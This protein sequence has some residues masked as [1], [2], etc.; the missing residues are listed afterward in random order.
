MLFSC[1]LSI[2]SPLQPEQR[3]PVFDDLPVFHADLLHDPFLF[4]RDLIH[5]FHG[6]YD[7][8]RVARVDAVA[9]IYEGIGVLSGS[10]IEYADPNLTIL[11]DWGKLP[12]LMRRGAAHIELSLAKTE[13][14][15]PNPSLVTRHSSLGGGNV[16]AA[17]VYR[18]SPGGRRLGEVPAEIAGSDGPASQECRLRFTART[19]LDPTTATYLYEI[20]RE[21]SAP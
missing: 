18:L 14:P 19:D 1:S 16:V 3:G 4:R 21:R 6:L 17:T 15:A 5:Q 8:Q 13:T 10:G 11:L 20:V 7:P 2:G 12:H 9:P